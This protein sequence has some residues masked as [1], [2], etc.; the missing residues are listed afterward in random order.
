MPERHFLFEVSWEVCNKVGGIHTVIRS[1]LAETIARFGEDY[2]LIGPMLDDMP[3]FEEEDLPEFRAVRHELKRQGIP[4]RTGR[5][6]VPERPKVILVGYK[7]IFDQARLLFHLW[8]DF[9][10]D[11]MTG[12]WDYVEPVLFSTAAAKAIEAAVLGLENTRVTALFHEWMTGGGLLYLKKNVPEV[13]LVFLTH[14]TMVGRAISSSGADLYGQLERIDGRKEAARFGVLAKHSMEQTAA[15]E[16]DCF[17]TVSE[18]TALE[19]T[20]LLGVRPAAVLP[21]GFIASALPDWSEEPRLWSES[22]QHLLSFASR[23]LRRELPETRTFILSTSGRFEFRNKGIDVLLESVA[24]LAKEGIPE[25]RHLLLFLFCL[26][27]YVDRTR[28]PRSDGSLEHYHGIATHPLWAGGQDPVVL[29]CRDLGLTNAADAAVSVIY[30]PVYLDGH[31]G[32]LNMEYYEALRGCDATAY[33]SYYEPWGYT[34]LESVAYSV[35]TLTTDLSGFGRWVLSVGEESE[36]V[37]VV[38]RQG[39][40]DREVVADLAAWLAGLMR[41]S[42]PA[43]DKL[44][45]RCRA[46]ALRADWKEFFPAYLRAFERAEASRRLRTADEAGE[47]RG[48][49]YGGIDSDRPRMKSFSVKAALP[50][51]IEGLRALS[52]NLWWSWDL[53]AQDLFSRLDPVLFERCNYNP[54][55]LLDSIAPEQLEAACKNESFM[56]NYENVMKRF[57]AYLRRP[58]KLLE[59]VEP[60]SADRP[61]AYFSME[62][63]LHESLPIYS[64]GLGV[65]AGDHIKSASD[66][67]YPLVGVGLMYK[68]G[69]FRQRVSREGNQ[70]EEYP[71]YDVFSMPVHELRRKNT[72]VLIPVE[73]P[74]R[75]VYVRVWQVKVGR[76][77]V[78]LLDTD[79]ADNT[80]ADREITARLYGGGRKTRIEQEMVLGIAGVRLLERELKIYPSVYHLNEGHSAF[81]IAERLANFMRYDDLDFETAR[82]LVR[83]STV[84]TTHTPVMAGNETFDISLVENYFKPYC[85]A[86]GLDWKAFADAGRRGPLADP[87]APYEMTVLALRHSCGRNGV[88]RLHGK[89]ARRMWKDLWPGLLEQEVPIGFITNGVHVPTWLTSEMKSLFIKY[90]GITLNPDLLNPTVWERINDIPDEVLWQTHV[91]LKNRLFALVRERVP[92]AW[93]REG[94]D[95]STIDDFLNAL[96]PSALTVGFARR[97]AQYKR[98]DLFLKNLN[99]LRQ[100]VQGKKP[101]QFV[102]AGKAHPEDKQAH[103]YIRQ[104]VE[105]AKSKEFLG[106]IIFLEDYDMRLARRIISGVDVWLNNPLRPNEASGTSGQ[107][108][109]INGVPNLSILDGWWDEAWNPEMPNGWA[110]GGRTD[111]PNPE[112]Q[113]LADADSLYDLLESEVIPAFYNN[114]TPQGVPERWVRVMKNSIISVIRHFNTHRMVRD[115]AELYYRPAA[116]KYFLLGGSAAAGAKELAAWKKDLP[117]RFSSLH[118]RSVTLQGLVDEN[119]NVGDAITVTVEIDPGRMTKEELKVEMVIVPEG[120]VEGDLSEFIVPCAAAQESEGRLRYSTTWTASKPGKFSYGVRVLPTHPRLNECELKDL[121]LVR[122]S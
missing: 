65:L 28:Q 16:A 31:D 9:G 18:I 39:R 62:F 120:G 38:R 97:I 52:A 37:R 121:N 118:I 47:R 115:Y 108:A 27:G 66:L 75:T 114:R 107:K 10:V 60:V 116:E 58:R 73:F 72:P 29:R 17:A 89:V 14:A 119:L 54:I 61:V 76:V 98:P 102:V 4:S 23:F 93:H 95:P 92:A 81:L 79:V 90:A 48:F 74:G 22:R 5:W 69:Y 15:R 110:I 83:A 7:G 59:D 20:N 42:E 8:E 11:S 53:E 63:G 70:Q 25:G 84:F 64:G 100:L 45:S 30:V 57:D 109:A 1:K 44:R 106:K 99:R 50:K 43:R 46:V 104:I 21:N 117:A 6:R 85:E 101:V 68:N 26:G 86:V 24:A 111:Y 78:Y 49:S 82:E 19:A 122:W 34:P 103:A 12:G 2:C 55:L 80:P 105:L 51:E 113:D 41:L 36:A 87:N 32:V 35:P 96:N 40:S 88:S 3:E 71:K 56:Q 91:A 112:T 77:T 33:P 94:E 13:G 67:N